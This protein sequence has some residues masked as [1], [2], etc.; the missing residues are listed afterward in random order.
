MARKPYQTTHTGECSVCGMSD[1]LV[2]PSGRLYKHK[3]PDGKNCYEGPFEGEQKSAFPKNGSLVPI[4]AERRQFLD[5]VKVRNEKARALKKSGTN[6]D[7][8]T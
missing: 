2:A 4:T 1:V 5:E 7:P 8:Q 6:K 3:K